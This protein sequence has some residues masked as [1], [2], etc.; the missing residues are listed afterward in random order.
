VVSSIE[1]FTLIVLPVPHAAASLVFP[2]RTPPDA[3]DC[4]SFPFVPKTP[5]Y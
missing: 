4:Q 2:T 3:S 1:F 5:S